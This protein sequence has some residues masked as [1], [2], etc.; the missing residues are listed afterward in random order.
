LHTYFWYRCNGN[1]ILNRNIEISFVENV[2]C[3]VFFDVKVGK[4]ADER[5]TLGRVN[6]DSAQRSVDARIKGAAC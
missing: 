2:V 6:K 5:K 1:K 4:L 3:A